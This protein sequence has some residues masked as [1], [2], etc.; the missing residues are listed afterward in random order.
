MSFDTVIMV[1]WSGGNDRGATPKKDAIWT[2]IARAGQAEAPLYHRNRQQAETYLRDVLATEHTAGR[3]T[4]AAFDLCFAYPTG[5]AEKLTG[6]D[7]PL[8]LWDWFEARVSD[9]LTGNS[10]FD[11]AGQINTQFPGTGPFWGN[12]RPNHDVP[13]LPRKGLDRSAHGLPEHRAT[14]RAAPGAFSPWQ[15]AGAGAVGGQVIMGLPMLSRLRHYFG[16]ALSVWPFQSPG[17]PIVLAESYFSLLPT[18]LLTDH[19]IRDAAQVSLYARAFSA[20]TPDQWQTVLD[21]APTPEGWVLGLGHQDLLKDAAMPDL[22]PPPLRNDCFAMPQGARWTPVD[23]ALAHLRAH[24]SPVTATETIPL[25]QAAGRILAAPVTAARS[26]PPHANAAVDGYAFAGPLAASPHTLPLHPGRAAAG[27]PFSGTVPRGH[28]LRILTGANIPAGTDTVVLQEDT[29]ANATHIALHG[30]LKQRANARKAGEDMAAGDEILPAR[31][32]LTPADLATLAACGTGSVTVHKRLRVGVLSTGDE[33]RPPGDTA[34]NGQ[35]YDA[36]RAMLLADIARWGH[37]AIDLGIAPDDRPIL[38][39][40]L[41]AAATQCDAILTSGGASA[42]DEDHMSALLQG[43]GTLALW[44]IAMKPGRPLALGIWQ[45]TPVFGLPGNPVAAQ[46]CALIFAH[47]ALAHLSSAD[48]PTPQGFTLPAAFTKS[49]KAGRREYLRAR[50]TDGAAEVFPSEGSGRV[51]GL[52]WATGLIVLPDAAA[53]ITPG[54]PVTYIPFAS[55][56]L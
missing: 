1:D 9:T 55:F 6:S 22:P 44:R 24:L 21:V 41:D 53:N 29:T 36:N 10:R 35:I 48:W 47:P 52:S 33:L 26:H 19:P 8:A 30:P 27:Q 17:T 15:L 14:D 28:P 51:S 37:Q 45:N 34:T 7:D 42:G 23:D 13:H 38:R 11:L 2:C 50:I 20:L 5:F 25:M 18:S 3:R 43:T 12:G 54:T 32:R 40:I 31:R 49:K 16:A 4:L 56:D 46:V 39:G